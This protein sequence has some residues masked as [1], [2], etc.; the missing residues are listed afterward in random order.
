MLQDDTLAAILRTIEPIDAKNGLQIKPTEGSSCKMN[1]RFGSKSTSSVCGF[2]LYLMVL[3]LSSLKVVAKNGLQIKPTE[4]KGDDIDVRDGGGTDNPK[5]DAAPNDN[6]AADPKPQ[7]EPEDNDNLEKRLAAYYARIHF[8][9]FLT[10]NKSLSA[11]ISEASS[12]M[13]RVREYSRTASVIL[14]G[15]ACCNLF[16]FS[17]IIGETSRRIIKEC[18]N[19]NIKTLTLTVNRMLTGTTVPQW[20]TMLYLKAICTCVHRRIR[21]C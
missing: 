20:D 16:L 8:F 3:P 11:G 1:I 5:D 14:V 15:V 10:C 19:Q 13:L 4:G 18:E 7:T 21:Q 6:P 12:K 2:I 17:T 9:A